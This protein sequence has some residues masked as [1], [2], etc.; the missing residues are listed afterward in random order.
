MRLNKEQIYIK[1]RKVKAWGT[2]LLFYL[3]RLFPIRRNRVV[4]CSF[5]GRGGFGCNPKY[6]VQQLHRQA[7]GLEIVWYVN[8]MTKSF[9]DY[10]KKVSNTVWNRAYYLST[11][12]VWIDNYRKPYGTCKRR[13]Q[14]YVNT[15]HAN[16]AFKS[17]GLLR[18]DAFSNMAYLVSKNDSDMIDDV[19]VDSKFCEILFRK[20]LL[21]DGPYQKVGQPRCD[22]LYGNRSKYMEQL[23]KQFALPQDSKIILYAPTFREGVHNGERTVFSHVCT[24]DFPRMLKNLSVRFGGTWYLFT[25]LHPQLAAQTKE[26]GFPTLDDKVIDVSCE[27]D[28][29]E[30]LAGVDAFLT[31]Y[32]SAAMDASY[33]GM[34]V[35]I[36]ADDIMQYCHDRGNLLWKFQEDTDAVVRSNPK[37]T[38][39]INVVLPYPIAKDNEELEKRIYDFDEETYATALKEFQT[40]VGL[41]FD[42]NASKQLAIHILEQMK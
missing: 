18:G 34:P 16:I 17:I 29:Y 36:Y 5:E 11:A 33:C 24:I 39:G 1:K 15:W 38:P 13:N 25:R 20:G 42:G 35:F 4:V 8:D 19:V 28:L 27:D 40:G 31:D 32:S 41:I 30:I 21:Y 3:C 22:V 12:K 7:P 6:V 26:N 37:T 23:R 2:R 14:Y 9:P 10:I